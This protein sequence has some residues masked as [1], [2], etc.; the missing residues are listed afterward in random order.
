MHSDNSFWPLDRS[1]VAA[2][3]DSADV[4]V[5]GFGAA[6]TSAILGAREADPEAE[7]LVLESTGGPGGAAALA[8]GIIYLLTES[9]DGLIIQVEKTAKVYMYCTL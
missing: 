5:I 8:G 3:D 1:E 7:I 9:L 2:F 6:G 4:I